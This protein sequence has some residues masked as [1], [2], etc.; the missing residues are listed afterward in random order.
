M[1]LSSAYVRRRLFLLATFLRLAARRPTSPSR[2]LLVYP[3]GGRLRQ[4][5]RGAPSRASWVIGARL[6]FLR[7]FAMG[8]GIPTGRPRDMIGSALPAQS[9]DFIW[10]RPRPEG[11]IYRKIYIYIAKTGHP[12]LRISIQTGWRGV[13]E[14]ALCATDDRRNWPYRRIPNVHQRPVARLLGPYFHLRSLDMPT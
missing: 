2:Y 6:H 13:S 11:P 12:V 3:G 1:G 4:K 7:R 10:V 9:S 14:L 5:A 8:G